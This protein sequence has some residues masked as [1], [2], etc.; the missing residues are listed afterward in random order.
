MWEVIGIKSVQQNMP[1]ATFRPGIVTRTYNQAYQ[2]TNVAV[3]P[4]DRWAI[5]FNSESG[6]NFGVDHPVLRDLMKEA[7]STVDPTARYEIMAKAA[8]FMY[9]NALAVGLYQQNL[10][11]PMNGTASWYEH[12]NFAETRQLTSFEWAPNLNK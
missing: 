4:L 2:H 9:D 11:L 1:Y 12:L 10:V 6:W 3:D 7:Q 5:A 8:A